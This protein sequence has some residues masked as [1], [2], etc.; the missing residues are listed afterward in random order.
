MLKNARSGPGHAIVMLLAMT[1]TQVI[2]TT[3]S[4]S[5]SG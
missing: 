4:P 5:R 2:D 3:I 1:M